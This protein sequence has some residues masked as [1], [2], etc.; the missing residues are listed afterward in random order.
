MSKQ[1]T[2]VLFEPQCWGFEH[3]SFNAALLVTV[4][5][6][7]PSSQIYFVGEKKHV[8][9]V[10]A[11]L[12]FYGYEDQNVIWKEM[13]IFRRNASKWKRWFNDL[14]WCRKILSVCKKVEAKVLILCSVN[15]TGLLA[16]KIL[17]HAYRFKKPT[18]AVMHSSLA[19]LIE[20]KS[21][22]A[23]DMHSAISFHPPSNLK[24]MVLGESIYEEVV[25]LLPH[26]KKQ[27]IYIDLPCLWPSISNEN[28]HVSK[29][30][31]RFG[32]LGS[33]NTGKG[34][35]LFCKLAD[36]IGPKYSNAQFI[37][38]GFF[39]GYNLTSPK[40]EYIQDIS[41]R[42]LSSDE[43]H[44][45]AVSLT[46]SVWLAKPEHYRLAASATFIDSLAYLK[47]GIYLRNPYIEHYVERMGDIGYL[48]DTFE[49]V[50]ST[51][52]GILDDFPLARYKQQIENIKK[53]RVIF[54]P[55]NLRN[56]LK[57]KIFLKEEIE[58]Y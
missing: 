3:S 6:A 41:D 22:R 26:H 27:W 17:I 28:Y 58:K 45:R 7:F 50:V 31:I 43:F 15:N 39:Y 42:P 5:L 14:S 56:K 54:E 33:A 48:C 8:I 20:R 16:L 32:F 10:K 25:K 44:Q 29:N 9:E 2:I 1:D 11:L 38:A 47:P 55:E 37:M 4:K 23:W 36:E 30:K 49:D 19:S 51:I 21:R 34:F 35:D 46:Y 24:L 52:S 18:V 53:G 40:S 12:S 13:A 57:Q